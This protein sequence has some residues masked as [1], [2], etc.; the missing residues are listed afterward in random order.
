MK[1]VDLRADYEVDSKDVKLTI[2]IGN[3]Q[4]GA[5]IVKLDKKEKGRGDINNVLIGSG[6][7]IRG[8]SIKT[9]SVVTDVNDQTNKTTI[10]YK[11]TGGMRDQEFTSSGTVDQ[12]GDSIIYRALFKLI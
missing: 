1:T 8:K 6:P 4:I 7:S 9:K 10:T 2:V 3:A 5:S 12:N 11:L